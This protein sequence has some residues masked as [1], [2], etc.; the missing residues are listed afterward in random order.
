MTRAE[1]AARLTE[2]LTQ[3]AANE[4]ADAVL[5]SVEVAILADADIGDVRARVNRRT[6]TLLFMS[7][8]LIDGAGVAVA[9]ASCVHKLTNARAT[10]AATA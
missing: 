9:T 3:A 8:E 7:A 10:G 5:I 6:K 1:I 2:A 4:A